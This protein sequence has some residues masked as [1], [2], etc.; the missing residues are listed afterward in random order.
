MSQTLKNRKAGTC[1]RE[2]SGRRVEGEN[3]RGGEKGGGGKTVM[4]VDWRI[5]AC[6]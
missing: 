6:Y 2:E 3:G 4:G 1:N 5:A